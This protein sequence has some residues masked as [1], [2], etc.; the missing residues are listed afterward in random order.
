MNYE[1]GR[2]SLLYTASVLWLLAW[3]LPGRAQPGSLFADPKASRIGDALTVVITENASASNRTAT[4]TDKSNKLNIGSTVPGGGNIL[5]FIPLHSL[6]SNAQNRFQGKASTTRS[7]NLSARVTVNVTGVKPN[8]DLVVEGVR[9]LKINGETEAI[10]LSGSVNP[11][12]I[13]RQNTVSSTNIADLRMEYTG[14]GAVTQG[15]RPGVIVRFLN[16]IF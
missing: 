7:A 5:D 14:R 9:T 8:G 15:T 16:W 1:R 6:K 2:I 4:S 10:Y 11:A 3:T 12:F 13:S